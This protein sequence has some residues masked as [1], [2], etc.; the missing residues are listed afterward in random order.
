M[1]V[2]KVKKNRRLPQNK[3]DQL[4]GKRKEEL[5]TKSG[6]EC[7]LLEKRG[8]EKI[9]EEK[10]KRKQRKDGEEREGKKN[11]GQKSPNVG[12]LK[13]STAG[14]HQMRLLHV[15]SFYH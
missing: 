11:L 14:V 10:K 4:C 7:R 8:K 2:H 6:T 3:D 13:T 12:C 5:G 15:H 9:R 1:I